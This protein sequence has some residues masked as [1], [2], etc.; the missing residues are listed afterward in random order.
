MSKVAN[1]SDR[2]MSNL[3]NSWQTINSGNKTLTSV[4]LY[5]SNSDTENRSIYLNVYETDND[6]SSPTPSQKFS[7]DPIVTSDTIVLPK[8]T[9]HTEFKFTINGDSLSLNTD[10]Y[11]HVVMSG[12]ADGVYIYTYWSESEPLVDGGV[13]NIFR[14][15]NHEIYGVDP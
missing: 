15:L 9:P 13:G 3:T 12:S 5:F 1:A 10:Y 11:I 6:P 4:N 7:G 14:T 8:N 2:G